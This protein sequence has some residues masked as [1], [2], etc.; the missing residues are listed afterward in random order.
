[1]VK[2]YT[3][4]PEDVIWQIEAGI[5]ECIGDIPINR[6]AEAKIE[7]TDDKPAKVDQN[8]MLDCKVSVAETKDNINSISQVKEPVV[9][10]RLD[11]PPQSYGSVPE[12]AILAAAAAAE[13]PNSIFDLRIAVENFED[14]VLK[15]TAMNTVFSDGDS[16]AKIMFIGTVP[17]A[18]EDR[19]GL[20]FVGLGGQLLNKMLASISLDRSSCYM[21]NIIFWRPPGDREPTDNEIAVCI[22]FVERHIE[23][24]AP[25]IIVL[26]G[27]PASKALLS[28]KQSINKIHGQYFKYST[29]K[30]KNPILA[31]P[32]YHPNNLLSSPASKQDAWRDLLKV[33]E[34]LFQK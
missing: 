15:K 3:S 33:K 29:K 27:G 8:V 34:K 7:H 20:P 10:Q 19:K 21:T 13:S 22:P 25:E 26:L 23:L 30:M 14:C 31:I 16:S 12:K 4:L 2:Y 28:M 11:L 32:L 17:G 1:M 5:D 18:D 6:F 9:K 24:V